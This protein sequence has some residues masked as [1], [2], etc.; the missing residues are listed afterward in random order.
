MINI[1]IGMVMMMIG[2]MMVVE[3]VG[4]FLEC[5]GIFF[6]CAEAGQGANKAADKHTTDEKEKALDI[7]LLISILEQIHF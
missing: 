2:M 3:E 4:R 6:A 7:I 5:H 1:M